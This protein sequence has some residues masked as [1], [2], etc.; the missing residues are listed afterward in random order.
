ME[1]TP[2]T[3]HLASND[4]VVVVAADSSD[5]TEFLKKWALQKFKKLCAKN[6]EL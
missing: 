4:L 1:H 5:Q 3:A 2:Y 6:V